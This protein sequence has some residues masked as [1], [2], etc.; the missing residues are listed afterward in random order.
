MLSQNEK[1]IYTRQLQI[2]GWNESKQEKLGLATVFVAGAGG[3]GSPLLFYLAAAGVGKL[4]I[5]D[6]DIIDISNLNRQIL[7]G[8]D[9]IGMM[10][11]ESADSRLKALNPCLDIVKISEPLSAQNADTL[12]AGADVIVDCLDNFAARHWLNQVSLKRQIPLIHA[13]IS[14]FQGHLT[15]LNPPETPCLAC[16][17]AED[18]TSQPPSVLGATAGVIGA[19]QATEVIKYLVGVGTNSKNKL[20]IYD[21]RKM[22]FDAMPISRNPECRVCANI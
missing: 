11:V 20:V 17:I 16:F 9:N 3:L 7:H 8:M 6:F 10:K 13:G 2:E 22:E 4:R 5:C 14:E 19:L 12:T 1:D 15:F 21:G 18:R